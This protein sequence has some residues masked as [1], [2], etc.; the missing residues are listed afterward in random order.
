[1]D[2]AGG[3]A[4]DRVG[5]ESRTGEGGATVPED[6]LAG[7]GDGPLLSSASSSPTMVPIATT[8]SSAASGLRE[9]NAAARAGR[10][11]VD[12]VVA[13]ALPF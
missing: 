4:G 3:E 12:A 7:A 8:T 5:A 2:A 10:A 6:G 9:T 13:S 1:M 11:G